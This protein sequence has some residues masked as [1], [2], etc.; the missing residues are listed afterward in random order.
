LAQETLQISENQFDI[1]LSSFGARFSLALGLSIVSDTNFN[2]ASP[3]LFPLS[4]SSAL[5]II[6]LCCIS[7]GAEADI[8]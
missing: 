3:F 7:M 6:M 1:H 2:L 5:I 4:Y 8:F